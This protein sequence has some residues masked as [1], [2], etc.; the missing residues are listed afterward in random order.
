MPPLLHIVD[1]DSTL[2][3]A[4]SAL[5]AGR[6][7]ATRCHSGGAE[8]LAQAAELR[9]CVLLDLDMAGMGGH[10]VLREIARRRLALKVVA[11]SAR[12]EVDEA[13]EAIKL[14]AVEFLRKPFDEEDLLAAVERTA[15]KALQDEIRRDSAAAA[16]A[17]LR[18][19]SPRERQVLQGLLAG[20]SNKA[21]AR[22]LGLSPRTIEMHRANMM[23]ELALSTLPEALRLAIEAGLTPLGE[24]GPQS[25]AGPMARLPAD[26]AV[27]RA[28]A[29]EE[30][31]RLVLEAASDGAWDWD[32]RTGRMRLSSSL[33]DRL[34]YVPEAVPD[35]LERYE[36]LLHPRDRATFRRTLEAHLAGETEAY[37]CTYRIRTRDGA[38][39]WTEVRG[40]VV[41]RDPADGAPLR[42][43]GTANDITRQ[44][45]GEERARES[46]ALVSLV[47]S[48]VGAG[49]WNLDL[50]TR[51]L[52]LCGRSR[53]LHGLPPEGDL[54]LDDWAA[55]VEPDDLAP[56]LEAVERAAADGGR[57]EVQFRV[58]GPDGAVRRILAAGQA[59]TGE[60]GDRRIVGLNREVAAAPEP[61][62]GGPRGIQDP[63]P[64]LRSGAEA[65]RRVR[66]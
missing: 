3:A 39:R 49:I 19:L 50:E 9:G 10:D 35:R 17:S 18:R 16:A 55:T 45:E 42:M 41:E 28:P 37:A 53:A 8:F 47:Q 43:I 36:D 23:S 11:A 66:R 54:H 38:W 22:V 60:G 1:D 44:R 34:G 15:R 25:A 20:L 7:F 56:A 21:M 46:S 64:H 62:P 32:L 2:R 52:H 14:G 48:S 61:H 29:P 12:A 59:V 24:A 6:G 40:R 57:F 65:L 33:V 30:E 58:R 13:V 5:F 51:R 27:P 31:L 26:S 63:H 4:T